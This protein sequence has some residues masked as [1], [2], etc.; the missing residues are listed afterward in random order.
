[1]LI[2][3]WYLYLTARSFAEQCKYCC[4]FCVCLHVV[5]RWTRSWDRAQS[6]G[7]FIHKNRGPRQRSMISPACMMT[8]FM[9]VGRKVEN[10]QRKNPK[11]VFI[12]ILTAFLVCHEGCGCLRSRFLLCCCAT[13][14]AWLKNATAL[15]YLWGLSTQSCRQDSF[16]LLCLQ[17]P[18][19]SDWNSRYA[20]PNRKHTPL[21]SFIY[22][23]QHW[24]WLQSYRSWSLHCSAARLSLPGIKLQWWVWARLAW[25]VLSAS[26]SR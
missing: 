17:N 3:W 19:R 22:T 11:I 23:F 7:L 5:S 13:C 9:K 12:W 1:M 24:K 25:P 10:G 18:V 16:L 26:C 21:S 14:Q 4:C 2:T 15:T 8:D 6:V 20:L